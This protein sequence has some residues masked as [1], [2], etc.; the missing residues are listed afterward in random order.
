LGMIVPVSRSVMN[1]EDPKA[2]AEA[3]RDEIN[4]IRIDVQSSF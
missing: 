4:R 1:A 3:L 2:A